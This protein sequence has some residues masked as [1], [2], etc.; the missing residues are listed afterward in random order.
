MGGWVV[1]RTGLDDMERNIEILFKKMHV[2]TI[3]HTNAV[4]QMHDYELS[5][6][7]VGYI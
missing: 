5:T 3:V 6:K 7:C 2:E 4:R 1:P